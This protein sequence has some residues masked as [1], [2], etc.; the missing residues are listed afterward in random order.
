MISCNV[1]HRGGRSA[2]GTCRCMCS[3]NLGC[4]QG[5]WGQAGRSS[6]GQNCHYQLHQCCLS[7]F[8]RPSGWQTVQY[9]ALS[10]LQVL[11][12]AGP[13]YM[14]A[15]LLEK[16]PEDARMFVYLLQGGKR[17]GCD[18]QVCLVY[19]PSLKFL[20]ERHPAQ[21]TLLPQLLHAVAFAIHQ[22][23]APGRSHAGAPACGRAS[24]HH[25]LVGVMQLACKHA[26]I[27]QSHLPSTCAT[28]TPEQI[29]PLH[30]ACT[31]LISDT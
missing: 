2:T 21:P 29:L 7:I 15:F 28:C 25:S 5:P 27:R 22:T 31:S 20:D 17:N 18:H 10:C 12:E 23:G 1:A 4:F 8:L 3:E 19:S 16:D 13:L 14:H 30:M 9:V 6:S 24:G 11:W 26:D